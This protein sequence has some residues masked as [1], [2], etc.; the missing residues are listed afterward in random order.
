[1]KNIKIFILFCVAL[2]F[3]T[4]CAKTG[5]IT[6]NN[7]L[8][9]QSAFAETIQVAST[10]ISDLYSLYLIDTICIEDFSAELSM[11]E[12]QLS[13]YKLEFISKQSEIMPNSQSFASKCGIEAVCSAFTITI[14]LLN[15]SLQ[16]LSDKESILNKYTIWRNDLTK[17]IATYFTAKQ[18]I[19]ETVKDE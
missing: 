12:T 15:Y 9:E 14:E 7:W 1:M 4:G 10:S 18:L 17:E 8:M 5:K 19:E 2:L 3:V 16:H 6:A 11:L 13:A